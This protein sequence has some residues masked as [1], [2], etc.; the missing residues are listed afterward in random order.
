MKTVKDYEYSYNHVKQRL[1]ERHDIEIDRAFYDRMN[2]QIKPYISNPAFCYVVD[3]NGEQEIHPMFIK[4][5]IIQVVYS[6]SRQRITTV[7]K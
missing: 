4:I 6:K 2:E 7:L 3:N 5:K 1:L